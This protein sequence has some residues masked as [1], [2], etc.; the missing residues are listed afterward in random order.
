MSSGKASLTIAYLTYR[1]RPLWEWFVASLAR[2]LRDTPETHGAQVLVIDGRLWTDGDAR[3]AE[4]RTL[5]ER[6]DLA[7]LASVEHH[8]PKP[9]VWQGPHRLTT[10]HEYFAAS[11]TRNTA[12]ALARG[13]HV[14]FVDDLSVLLPGWAKAHLH[15][16]ANGYVLGGTTTKYR[17]VQV[18][19][20]GA[21]VG[22]DDHPPGRDSRLAWLPPGHGVVPLPGSALYGG[23][24]SVPLEA[25]LIV[26]GQDEAC[27]SISGEDYD[28]GMRL[29][30]A[31]WPV[32]FSR[33]CATIED[34]AHHAQ[35]VMRRL[36][37]LVP[38]P[39]GPDSSHVLLRRLQRETSRVWT[40][41]EQPNLRE[42]RDRVLLGE[43]FPVPT[44]P[45]V[46]W[47]DGQPLSEM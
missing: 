46:H 44:E 30:R 27:D 10:H 19:A 35:S 43:P 1:Q 33:A 25:A 40:L 11:S 23:T 3:R 31:G 24:F 37:K 45:S 38:G 47:P 14:A 34:D 22:I 12:L 2:E 17:N 39:D 28:F 32:R 41:G 7:A 20:T 5:V 6:S 4:L 29:E 15:A 8:P 42:L 18:D 16:M 9:C 36:D 21:V 26:N 13:S